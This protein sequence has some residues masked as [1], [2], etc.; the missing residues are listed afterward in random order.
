MNFVYICFIVLLIIFLYPS[1]GTHLK[2]SLNLDQ[3]ALINKGKILVEMLSGPLQYR[4]DVNYKEFSKIWR[5]LL[6][7]Q[8]KHGIPIKEA[9]VQLRKVLI[10]DLRS[11]KKKQQIL[12]SCMFQGISIIIIEILFALIAISQSILSLNLMEVLAL[13]LWQLM[14]LFVLL[15]L[16]NWFGELLFKDLKAYLEEILK[17]SVL[18]RSGFSISQIVSKL[19]WNKLEQI[20]ERNLKKRSEELKNRVEL[21]KNRGIGL[22]D[23]LQDEMNEIEFLEENN[24]ELYQQKLRFFSFFTLVIFFLSSFLYLI[25]KIS[26]GIV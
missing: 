4:S 26:A 20:K 21:W 23:W 13:L 7:W 2:R 3:L 1:F 17:F 19:S 12:R 5:Q 6:E 24:F 10:M 18:I 14:G 25:F 9:L 15:F 11:E 8:G 16:A 22:K